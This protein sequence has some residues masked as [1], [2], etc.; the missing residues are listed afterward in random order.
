MNAILLKGAW[1]PCISPNKWL[2]TTD[3][4][5]L[6]HFVGEVTEASP[7]SKEG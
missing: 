2:R 6:P 5:R 7:I 4:V 3:V 1:G